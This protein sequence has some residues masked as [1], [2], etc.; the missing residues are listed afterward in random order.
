[1]KQ[2]KTFFLDLLFPQFCLQCGKEGFLV[3]PDCLFAVPINPYRY[4]PF[5][6][7]PKRVVQKGKCSAHKHFKLNGLFSATAYKEPLVKKMITSFKYEPYVKDLCGALSFLIISHLALLDNDAV[8]RD[9]F[10]RFQSER[11]VF[12]PVPLSAKKQKKRGY[13]QSLLLAKILSLYYQKP[14]QADN[15]LKIRET[16]SQTQLK[17]E[18]RWLNMNN[19][20]MV[21]DASLVQGKII[22]LVDDVFTTGATMEQCALVLKAAGAKAVWGI[23]V[24]RES[25][26]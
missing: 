15:L 20:F 1:M 25:L 17:R 24:A 22:F 9:F 8:A 2:W 12:M 5:C 4:C 23:V 13:N 10:A 7:I 3:C 14:L 21:Q 19:A 16:V 11:F 18:Q 6:S 26:S